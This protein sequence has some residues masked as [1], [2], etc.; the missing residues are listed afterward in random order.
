MGIVEAAEHPLLAYVKLLSLSHPIR[1][2]IRG[3]LRELSLIN[4]STT[5]FD[6]PAPSDAIAALVGPCKHLIKLSLSSRSHPLFICGPTEADY[7]H[8]VDEAFADHAHLIVLNVP[9]SAS[10]LP[11][12][13]RILSHLPGLVE[14]HTK[15]YVTGARDLLV[16]LGRHCPKLEVL[17]IAGMAGGFTEAESLRLVGGSLKQLLAPF[18]LVKGESKALECLPALERVHLGSYTTA[19]LP[20]ASRLTHLALDSGHIGDLAGAGVCRLESLK[21]CCD[22]ADPH[23]IRLLAANQATLRTVSFDLS[24]DSCQPDAVPGLL[25]RLGALPGLTH[26]T[27]SL[28]DDEVVETLPESILLRLEDLALSGG[29]FPGPTR[30]VSRTIRRLRLR[31]PILCA[32]MTVNCPMLDELTVTQCESGPVPLVL[33]CPRLR[34]LDMTTATPGGISVEAFLS[35]MPGLTR[36]HCSGEGEPKWLFPLLTR[37][38][39]L[40]DLQVAISRPETL[41][42]LATDGA[43]CTLRSLSLSLDLTGF[44]ESVALQMPQLE[45]LN[46]VFVRPVS[47]S[48]TMSAKNLTLA[49]ELPRIRSLSL[50]DN[51]SIPAVHLTLRCPVLGDL[52]VA[53]P[54]LVSVSIA[55][56]APPPPLR[57][58]RLEGRQNALEGASLLALLTQA[59]D[60]LARLSIASLSPSCQATWPALQAALCRLPQLALLTLPDSC[61]PEISLACPRLLWLGIAPVRGGALIRGP[62]EPQPAVR[63]LAL[64]CPSLVELR[65]PFGPTLERYEPAVGSA[66][67]L[68]RVAGVSVPWAARL[69]TLL[70]GVVVMLRK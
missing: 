27:L 6:L 65:A 15:A 31:G 44:P 18:L 19:L 10:F 67:R 7:G 47:T 11:A 8:W 48:P 49:C 28:P 66:R 35:I 16:A 69:K 64:D 38:P 33:N 63:S 55:E 22:F 12:L 61:I 60:R 68:R 58:L 34:S 41:S 50:L 53:A 25:A 42:H 62:R 51:A 21:L 17:H 57:S 40:A 59:G 54:G 2:A 24:N 52:L 56:A 30:I 45:V 20:I 37:S 39:R 4:D 46:V 70:A 1:T 14:F 5:G 3:N 36:A 43:A 29:T 23:V 9:D 13:P 32:P 26:L